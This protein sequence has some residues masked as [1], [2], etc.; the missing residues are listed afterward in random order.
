MF[1][2]ARSVRLIL[3]FS[4]IVLPPAIASP[5]GAPHTI[6]TQ[7]GRKPVANF[8]QALSKRKPRTPYERIFAPGLSRL[9]GPSARS[10]A[11]APSP[12][13]PHSL[14]RSAD[15]T[16]ASLN[17][18]G[19]PAAPV[20]PA[21]PAADTAAGFCA[22][23]NPVSADFNQD[24][25]PDI[26]VYA[27]H[28]FSDQS[29]ELVPMV[30]LGDGK[31]GLG[32]PIVSGGGSLQAPPANYTVAGKPVA[33]DM[34]GDGYPDLVVM[35]EGLNSVSGYENYIV[36][37]YINQKD[38]TFAAPIQAAQAPGESLVPQHS[39]AQYPSTF[40][41]ADVNGDGRPD[42]VIVGYL[43]NG[44]NQ[45]PANLLVSTFLG[46][47]NNQFADPEGTGS[48]LYQ[49]LTV[50]GLSSALF[51]LADVNKDGHPDL[52]LTTLTEAASVPVTGTS[53]TFVALGN[54][55]GSFSNVTT[56]TAKIMSVTG[57]QANGNLD[58]EPLNVLVAD[59]NRDGNPDVLMNLENSAYVA[60]GNGDGTF[61]P[62]ITAVNPH[63]DASATGVADMN[64]DGI[65]D[66]ILSAGD[67]TAIYLGAGDGT[68]SSRA[69]FALQLGL[70]STVVDLNG[71]GALDIVAGGFGGDDAPDSMTLSN[72]YLMVIP[73]N[74]D[75]TLATTPLLAWNTSPPIVPYEFQLMGAGDVNGDH[76]TDVLL[77][78]D[79][80]LAND[81]GADQNDLVSGLSNGKGGFTYVHALSA[82]ANANL[83][84]VEPTTADFN[85]DGKQ[86]IL[87]VG[88]DN[89]LS[90]ALSKGDGTFAD[91]V[92]VGL[93][94]LQ[95]EVTYS[96][97]GDLNGDGKL[98]IVAPYPGD[99]ACGGS[100]GR[101]A[102]YFVALGKG[103]GTF[104][105]PVYT[106]MCNELY[107]ATLADFNGDGKL[108]LVTDDTP[109]N[110]SGTFDVAISLGKGDG[111]FAPAQSVV[112]SAMVSQVIA[113]D[114][115]QDG[116][117][118]LVLL[119]AGTQSLSTTDFSTAGVLL[120]PGKGDGTF[121]SPTQI[122][123]GSFFSTGALL[124]VNGDGIPDLTLAQTNFDPSSSS[125][126]GM[127]TLLGT[128]GGSFANPV[129]TYLPSVNPFQSL[130][131][132]PS[133]F[134]ILLP[135]NFLSD[136]APDFIAG[137]LPGPALF[138]GQGGS[139]MSLTPSAASIV[140]GDTETLTVQVAPSMP[141]RPVP[142]GQVS[143]YDGTTL[144]GQSAL[145][146]TGSAAITT[147][148]LAV[149]SHTITANHAGDAST[150]ANSA[151]S[152]I[153]VTALA[154]A[155][156]VTANPATL[157]VTQGQSGTAT[158]TVVANAAYSGTVTFTCSGLPANASCAFTPASIQ[159]APGQ[160]LTENLVL[161]TSMTPSASTRTK[162]QSLSSSA[163]EFAA[164]LCVLVLPWG[165]RW[166]KTRKSLMMPLVLLMLCVGVFG[167]L[168]GCSNG[169]SQT[170]TS[171]PVPEAP[172]GTSNIVVNVLN[173]A[174]ASG[175][176]V[177]ITL[178]V[179]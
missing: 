79:E 48:P 160:T 136:N 6:S 100:G 50:P 99:A 1:R 146:A 35:L 113:G 87:F 110:V 172:K 18:A 53:T 44:D 106:A 159:I 51:T 119:S 163:A 144:I 105:A 115:N 27:A 41:I 131:N 15:D 179:Q 171:I 177:S 11:T 121:G 95:C 85:N 157:T 128:G 55:D 34:N 49:Q 28:I 61:Q 21:C 96:V 107:S 129:S 16:P 58:V 91:P 151:S 19:Y 4:S 97:A 5:A 169:A 37:I 36:L 166:T 132:P 167:A 29:A 40:A 73:G 161:S 47:G 155:L 74:G 125:F 150:N 140:A 124:D 80:N 83:G 164:F 94:A 126:Y 65:P 75:G 168:S 24:G 165:K 123:A 112:M 88:A 71:D 102:G 13:S 178:I 31:G 14:V 111:T 156:S 153:T 64:G 17:F 67:D 92:S 63:L 25:K 152:T 77:N 114:F 142:T 56:G 42:I 174:N 52:V 22:P 90:V 78:N 117:P 158:L 134:T 68:F 30:L 109:Y 139:T 20:I 135:G 173:S 170:T 86:D 175:Q 108:D 59:L 3:L 89:S 154:P 76:F 148:S 84:Y 138:L 133:S 10:A 2:S 62:Q 104:A 141:H 127:A 122:A 176:S 137:T 43:Q 69:S 162:S 33:V 45:E 93:P 72:E 143:F 54:G 32:A 101:A 26:A 145:D 60:L 38:G 81:S 149:G 46:T 116:K 12:T 39:G 147:A 70:N 57:T 103:D 120:V 23:L 98:D 7:F 9:I 8:S 130:A 66:L 118:D 82:A